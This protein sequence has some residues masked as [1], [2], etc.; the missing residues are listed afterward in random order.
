[1]NAYVFRAAM[2][3]EE[4]ALNE[5]AELDAQGFVVDECTDSDDYPQGPYADGG[6]E[7]DCPQHCDWCGAFLE[8][9]LTE[10]GLE[11]VARACEDDLMSGRMA[12]VALSVWAEFYGFNVDET[13]VNEAP[14]GSA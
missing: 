8:N 5:R 3:C 12:T 9:P 10:E 4:C 13:G 6:G 14:E 2:W 11:Y 7:A 1:M